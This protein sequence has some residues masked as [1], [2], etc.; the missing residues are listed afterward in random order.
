M[1]EHILVTQKQKLEELI[2]NGIDPYPNKYKRTHSI[3]EVINQ[4]PELER[5]KTP[6]SIAGRLKSFRYHGKSSFAHLMDETGSL[7]IYANIESLG[8][9]DYFN[10][11]SKLD[12]GDII[13]VVGTAFLTKTLE[14]TLL[15]SK[16]TL[17]AKAMRPLPEKWH[18]LREVERRY[19][20]RYLDL[21]ANPE[22]KEIFKKRS[23]I[24]STI[25]QFL[26][27][28][29]YIEVETPILQPKAGGAEAK[30]FIT[31]HNALN[32][33]LY[34][35]IA[36]ELYL[37]RLLVGGFEKIYELNYS[38][39]NEGISSVHNPEFTMLEVYTAY[40]DYTEMMELTKELICA[41]CQKVC[42]GLEFVYQSHKINLEKEWEKFT[43]LEAIEKYVDIKLN[44][45][46]DPE[47]V[48]SKISGLPAEKKEAL[49]ISELKG[50][51]TETMIMEIFK[52]LV[53]DKLINPTFII[54]HPS[55]F[56]PLA[57]IKKNIS[58][59]TSRFQIAERFELYIG[60]L[61][62]ANAYS[63][64]NDPQAQRN[65]FLTQLAMR[66]QEK[67]KQTH[68]PFLSLPEEKEIDEE[69]LIA[70]EYG[71]PPAAGLG[72]GIDRLTMLLTDS[73]SIREVILFPLLRPER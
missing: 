68:H 38:F 10:L 58:E 5:N 4:F 61:E 33:I 26:N 55:I 69:Y 57:K 19:R 48:Y 40:S 23:K 25:R 34:L 29:G 16:C 72:I 20:E 41:V 2:R 32:M 66:T 67:E 62:L 15:I 73:A 70:L 9:N 27:D 47:S 39:R 54:D 1:S 37:K 44:W 65:S 30:P 60:G 56:S 28:R 64:Q 43:I 35:R 46:E 53:E 21:I 63:E 49:P 52:H 24:I 3:A 13:G 71:M 8:E 11:F 14:K 59:S 6:I 51:N 22:K 31:Y 45:D 50:K 7:Q 36:P 12:V 18:G 42:G 17:L